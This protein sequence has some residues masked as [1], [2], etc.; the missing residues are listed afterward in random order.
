[1]KKKSFLP[2]WILFGDIKC[3]SGQIFFEFSTFPKIQLLTPEMDSR[4]KT[5]PK[6]LNIFIFFGTKIKSFVPNFFWK[7]AKTQFS[8]KLPGSYCFW[9]TPRNSGQLWY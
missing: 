2:Q 9:V 5:K 8:N 4:P 7:I 6:M 3:I 1:M